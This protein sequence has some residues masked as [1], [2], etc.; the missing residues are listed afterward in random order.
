MRSFIIWL[1]ALTLLGLAT[2]CTYTVPQPVVSF[3]AQ[4]AAFHGLD[5]YALRPEIDLNTTVVDGERTL[6]LSYVNNRDTEVQIESIHVRPDTKHGSCAL[7]LTNRIKVPALTRASIPLVALEEVEACAG[8]SSTLVQNRTLDSI[9]IGRTAPSTD[10]RGMEVEVEFRSREVEKPDGW[11]WST[12]E[13][14]FF[15]YPKG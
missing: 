8:N 13:D 6:Q 2:G 10:F 1:G 9:S 3:N 12:V 7:F 5:G 11:R 4:A 15:W 14:F